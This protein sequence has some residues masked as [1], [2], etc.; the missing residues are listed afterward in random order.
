MRLIQP[1]VGATIEH[2]QPP[3]ERLQLI[4]LEICVIFG[5]IVQFDGELMICKQKYLYD[6][7]D[8]LIT[9]I[10]L[11]RRLQLRL[12]LRLFALTK[13]EILIGKTRKIETPF[14]AYSRTQR[15]AY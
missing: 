2:A 14:G 1:H 10:S 15:G 11:V 4:V 12:R 5:Y 13:R 7:S 3:I 6:I 9:V 8:A